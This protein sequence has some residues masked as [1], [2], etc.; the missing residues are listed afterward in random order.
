MASGGLEGHA[1]DNVRWSADGRRLLFSAHEKGHA[2][3]LF[4]Q[5]GAEEH[6]QILNKLC[7]FPCTEYTALK[8]AVDYY[9][10]TGRVD[11]SAK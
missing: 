4:V 11:P 9:K 1:W 5:R 8:K 6:L 2:D 10:Q 7:F 3:R